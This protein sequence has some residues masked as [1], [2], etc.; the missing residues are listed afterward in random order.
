MFDFSHRKFVLSWN[1]RGQQEL[2]YGGVSSRAANSW[3]PR[4]KKPFWFFGRALGSM[5]DWLLRC[6]FHKRVHGR[7]GMGMI[8]RVEKEEERDEIMPEENLGQEDE[9]G[10][11]A[12]F[13][14]PRRRS[15]LSWI[16]YSWNKQR[17][18]V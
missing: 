6:S 11:E 17:S 12:T 14:A 13:Q 1:S 16:R 8:S 5:P 15:H 9:G 3:H 4:A 10:S 18:D 2:D 7:C